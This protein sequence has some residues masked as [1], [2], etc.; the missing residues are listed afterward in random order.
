VRRL[1]AK[2]GKPLDGK[3]QKKEQ[4]RFD[5]EF[6]KLKKQQAARDADPKKQ[7]QE[8]QRGELLPSQ[9]LRLW[10]F[11]NARR[12]RFRGHDVIAVDFAANPAVK[13]KGLAANFG[14]RLAGVMW[15]D[16]QSLQ[17][18]RIEARFTDSVK[19]GGILASLEKG[20]NIV[21]EQ[22]KMNDEVWL[23][24]Y[25]EGHLGARLLF[26]KIKENEIERYTDCKKFRVE[27]TILGV[28]QN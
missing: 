16:E 5:K 2:D 15:I 13:P 7:K 10:S 26:F 28:H 14:Y 3:E 11:S 9:L 17:I 25:R 27:S 8:E 18:A 6:D 23:P 19:I 12:E 4:E 20:S 22:A 1:L 24:V 21:I